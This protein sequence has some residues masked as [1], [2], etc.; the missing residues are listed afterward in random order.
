MGIEQH[1]NGEQHPTE[2]RWGTNG[3]EIIIGFNGRIPDTVIR[4]IQDYDAQA[5]VYSLAPDGN[6]FIGYD[7]QEFLSRD[8]LPLDI[9]GDVLD[10]LRKHHKARNLGRV[11][12]VANLKDIKRKKEDALF[13]DEED[14]KEQTQE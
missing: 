13:D 5:S 2:V 9:V 11:S 4:E 12:F 3:E 6:H 8:K 10:P 1:S 7:Q 14:T